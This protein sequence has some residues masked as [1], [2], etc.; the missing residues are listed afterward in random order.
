M[1]FC[2]GSLKVIKAGICVFG[3]DRCTEAM[4]YLRAF[5]KFFA[6]LVLFFPS[7]IKFGTGR[8]QKKY[9]SVDS[10]FKLGTVKS[11]TEA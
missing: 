9:H 1:Q 2:I 3:E 10:F 11:R 7:E 4:L 8:V 6:C 5:V